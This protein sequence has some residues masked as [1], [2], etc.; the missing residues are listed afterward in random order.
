MKFVNIYWQS[1][2]YHDVISGNCTNT[3]INKL[4]NFYVIV[5]FQGSCLAS[6]LFYNKYIEACFCTTFGIHCDVSHDG[7]RVVSASAT[8]SFS[9]Q[10]IFI[11]QSL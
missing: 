7:I 8:T 6:S 1:K 5:F 11:L 9:M 10:K 2:V 4:T 3:A